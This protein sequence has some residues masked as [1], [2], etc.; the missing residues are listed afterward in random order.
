MIYTADI[1]TLELMWQCN[2]S[3]EKAKR[4]VDSYVDNNKQDI[5]MQLLQNNKKVLEYE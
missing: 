4:I 2:Y 1:L 5:L 3:A